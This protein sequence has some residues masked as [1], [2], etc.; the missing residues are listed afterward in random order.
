M[1]RVPCGKRRGH[2][3]SD[4]AHS[5]LAG[6]WFGFEHIGDPFKTEIG[7]RRV[8]VAD[9]VFQSGIISPGSRDGHSREDSTFFSS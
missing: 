2:G 6:E 3:N 7:G 5:L 4:K 8:P 1:D 9:L